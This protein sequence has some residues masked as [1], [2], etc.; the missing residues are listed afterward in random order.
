MKA[1]KDGKEFAEMPLRDTSENSRIKNGLSSGTCTWDDN[2]KKRAI[3]AAR[4]LNSVSKG[5]NALELSTKLEEDLQ[6]NSPAFV[7]PQY[8]KDALEWLFQ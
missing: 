5:E 6:S 4:Y 3:I 1:Y 8:L 7:V 2:E